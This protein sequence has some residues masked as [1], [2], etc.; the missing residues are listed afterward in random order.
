MNLYKIDKSLRLPAP[1]RPKTA[2]ETSKAAHT[3]H[4]LRVGE[5]F[6][7]ADP[8]GGLKAEKSMRDLNAAERGRAS[9]RCYASRRMKRGVR[10]WRI[11]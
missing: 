10:I 7:V 9:G 1:S 6:L 11:R 2:S 3:M 4:A 8:Y 5:S